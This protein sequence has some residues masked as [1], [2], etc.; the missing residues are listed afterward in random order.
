MEDLRRSLEEAQLDVTKY[1]NLMSRYQTNCL[2]MK[3]RLKEKVKIMRE[4][5]DVLILKKKETLEL[6]VQLRDL[7]EK[8]QHMQSEKDSTS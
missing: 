1:K 2:E 7:E 4:Q 8:F 3:K 5:E 6:K